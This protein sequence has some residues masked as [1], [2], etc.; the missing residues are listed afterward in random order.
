MF[1]ILLTFAS[2]FKIIFDEVS[3]SYHVG[4]TYSGKDHREIEVRA[5]KVLTGRG[6][7][8]HWFPAYTLALDYLQIHNERDYAEKCRVMEH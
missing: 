3:P 1:F 8:S 7:K 6:S 2:S 5:L 4:E